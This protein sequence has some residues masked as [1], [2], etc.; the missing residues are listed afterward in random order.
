MNKRIFISV[1]AIVVALSI[2]YLFAKKQNKAEQVILGESASLRALS[3]DEKIEEAQL[4]IIGRVNTTLPSKWKFEHEKPAQAATYREIIDAGGL[5]TDSLIL[6]DQTLKGSVDKPVVRVRTFLG[7]TDSVRWKDSSEILYEKGR[8]YLLFL[9]QDIGPT[10]H[11]DPEHYSSVNA[12]TAIYEIA[13]NKAISADD[14]W[15]LDELIA[16]IQAKLAEADSTATPTEIPVES[17]ATEPPV[18]ATVPPEE[19]VTTEPIVTIPPEETATP[20]P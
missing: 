9:H 17:T 3:I 20:A 7:E 5:F 1:F 10:A 2:V 19:T 8:T 18:E 16:Y 14:A 15:N 12:H 11:I 13:G 4:I 6:V